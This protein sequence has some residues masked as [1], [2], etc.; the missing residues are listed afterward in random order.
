MAEQS[1]D[2]RLTEQVFLQQKGRQLAVLAV[3]EGELVVGMQC[4]GD[5]LGQCEVEVD[6]R[7][8]EGDTGALVIAGGLGELLGRDDV[9]F[10]E[11][12][13]DGSSGFLL[14]ATGLLEL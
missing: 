11:D 13:S 10:E 2:L 8:P 7:P 3:D 6:E 14:F 5:L 12:L 1:L 4:V 9:Q